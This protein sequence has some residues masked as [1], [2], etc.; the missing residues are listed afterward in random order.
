MGEMR[1]AHKFFIRKPEGGHS[2]DLGV[3]GRILIE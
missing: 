1:N 3:V 2:E